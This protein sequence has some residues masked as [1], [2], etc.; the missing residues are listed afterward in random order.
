MNGDNLGMAYSASM[1]RLVLTT[2]RSPVDYY[3]SVNIGKFRGLREGRVATYKVY[4]CAIARLCSS[5]ISFDYV[6][7]RDPKRSFV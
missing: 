5:P 2:R 1:K 7:K 6:V 3:Q 4:S